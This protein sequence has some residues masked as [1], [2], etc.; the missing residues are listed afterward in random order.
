[1][2]KFFVFFISFLILFASCSS[3]IENTGTNNNETNASGKI[4]GTVIYSNVAENQN[5]GIVV[6]LDKTDGLNTTAVSKS[7]A[8]RSLVNSS[9]TI[10]S[11]S[12][13]SADGSYSF[14]GLEAGTYTV[15]AVSSYS[16]ESSNSFCQGVSGSYANPVIFSRLAYK[17][18]SS[19]AI[20]LT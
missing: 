1:M 7:I 11:S 2:N 5:G 9:R 16:K 3:D 10:I 4:S 8:S 19:F 12:T 20:S 14:S 6:T 15:Y 17:S 18:I 13:T